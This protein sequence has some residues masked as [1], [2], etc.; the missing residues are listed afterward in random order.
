MKL[1]P[2]LELQAHLDGQLAPRDQL[3]V[4]Q[5]LAEDPA[6]RALRDELEGLK[7]LLALGPLPRA[8]PEP[9]AFYWSQIQRKIQTQEA[10]ER[11]TDAQRPVPAW[12]RSLVPLGAAVAMAVILA[13][14]LR[15]QLDPAAPVSAH[16][17]LEAG[18][19]LAEHGSSILFRS[20]A[21]GITVVWVD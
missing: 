1:D 3:R 7:R 17:G 19:L 11:R 8:V 15:V 18:S 4:E 2:Q 13:L 5:A 10:A 21:E 14:A 9:E 16:R 6:R 12:K 20:E